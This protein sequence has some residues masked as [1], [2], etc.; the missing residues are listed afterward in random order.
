M[1][2]HAHANKTI[3]RNKL[4]LVSAIAPTYAYASGD[5]TVLY[6]TALTLIA[7]LWAAILILL[8]LKAKERIQS[9]CAL[10]ICVSL[11]GAIFMTT[12]YSKYKIY[13]ETFSFLNLLILFS[14]IVYKIK[15]TK[16]NNKSHTNMK[17]TKTMT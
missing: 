4:I 14:F 16:K 15:I 5:V 13:I 12:P 11:R 17:P 9:L 10:I 6:Y 7:F 1:D 8:K 3:I 2:F